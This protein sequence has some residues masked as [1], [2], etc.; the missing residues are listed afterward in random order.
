MTDWSQI[1]LGLIAGATLVMALVQVGVILAAARLAG[2]VQGTL[3]RAREA[4]EGAQQTVASLRED[5]RPLLA[6][7]TSIAGDAARSATL[8]AAQADKIDRLVTDLTRRVDETA[9]VVQQAIVT[10]AREG[11]AVLAAVKAALAVF[12]QAGDPRRRASRS[13]EEDPLFIG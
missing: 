12:R 13:E 10:P 3:A 2:Q 11:I 5:V 6:D 1:F 9:A 7:A 8:A 4:I